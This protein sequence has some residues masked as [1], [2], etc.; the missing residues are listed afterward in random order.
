MSDTPSPASQVLAILCSRTHTSRRD[1]ASSGLSVEQVRRALR[2]LAP[3]LMEHTRTDG[4]K[5]YGVRDI[6]LARRIIASR[7]MGRPPA[8]VNDIV[9]VMRDEEWRSTA[10]IA[11]W[12]DHPTTSIRR[13]MDHRPDLFSRRKYPT[14]VTWRLRND[15]R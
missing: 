3:A 4:S 12:L 11:R 5:V 1:L 14:R 15:Y 9:E 8:L 13:A 2:L 10:T 7:R 6:R